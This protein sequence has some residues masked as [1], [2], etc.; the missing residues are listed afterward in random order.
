M[1]D[2]QAYGPE[3]ARILALDRDSPLAPDLIR[4][5][6]LPI[7]VRAGLYLHFARWKEAHE[8]VDD[9]AIPEGCYWHAI[10][11]RLEPDAANAAYWYRHVGDHPIFPA[12]RERA[13]EAGYQS[14]ARWDPIAFIAYNE[15]AR[16]GSEEERIARE[17]RRAEWEL[18]F[19]Y[20]ARQ[21]KLGSP[22]PS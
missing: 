9:S 7:L 12:L 1:F 5:S 3:V 15:R 2:P 10:V 8:L 19:D 22:A 21:A 18:L 13:A 20:C 14:G 16:P 4:Q 17:V 11:H 6:A